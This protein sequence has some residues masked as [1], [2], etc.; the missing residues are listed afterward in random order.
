V[1]RLRNEKEMYV[2]YVVMMALLGLILVAKNQQTTLFGGVAVDGYGNQ[3]R[4]EPTH[5]KLHELLAGMK[6]G[7]LTRKITGWAIN[8]EKGLITLYFSNDTFTCLYFEVLPALLK[9]WP[10]MKADGMRFA[11][12][13]IQLTGCGPIETDADL[14]AALDDLKVKDLSLV[15][16]RKPLKSNPDKDYTHWA[17]KAVHSKN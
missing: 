10:N 5:V 17:I 11:E 15:L 13:V 8:A 3:E 9:K 2:I 6:S 4:K 12:A 1:S 14:E 7:K 16:T